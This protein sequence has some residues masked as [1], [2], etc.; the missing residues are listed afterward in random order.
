MTATSGGCMYVVWTP[1]SFSMNIFVTEKA[2]SL[3]LHLCPSYKWCVRRL[4]NY[5]N[6]TFDVIR[7]GC[8]ITC[9]VLTNPGNSVMWTG[10]RV[11]PRLHAD[12]SRYIIR[13]WRWKRGANKF[14]FFFI[15]EIPY[16]LCCFVSPPAQ[17][18]LLSL[19]LPIYIYIYVK[20][21]CSRYGSGLAQRVGRGI[22]LFFHDRGTRRGRVV[23][24]TPRPHFTPGKVP[25]PILQEAGWAPGPVWTGGKF[26]PHR[27]SIS[28]LP[29]R[30]QSL[31]RLSYPA[32]T[33]THTHILFL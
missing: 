13:S 6:E 27:D 16:G 5:V 25:V 19:Q 32:H 15:L 14:L 1:N 2:F 23:S 18:A 9:R 4:S 30:S 28:D 8:V 21:K 17:Y 26:R 29:A 12:C 31:Y 10:C 3:L 22:A 20:V 11:K 24:S 33:H 7:T